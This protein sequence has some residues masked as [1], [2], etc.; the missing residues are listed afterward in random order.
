MQLAPFQGDART[1]DGVNYAELR[2][3]QL[4]ADARR[5]RRSGMAVI[6]DVGNETDIHPKQKEP[7]GERLALAARGIAYGKKIVYQRPGVQGREVR[8]RHRRR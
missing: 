3:A 5:C 7:V 1:T 2:D 6:T 8:E 4:H